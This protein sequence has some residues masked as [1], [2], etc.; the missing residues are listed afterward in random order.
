MILLKRHHQCQDSSTQYRPV[1]RRR[2]NDSPTMAISISSSSISGLCT[3][4]YISSKS[5]HTFQPS[6][7]VPLY[8]IPPQNFNFPMSF[9][10][11]RLSTTTPHTIATISSLP[12]ELLLEILSHLPLIDI[13]RLSQ[14]CRK[15]ELF[16]HF[17]PK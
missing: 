4:S 1:R 9:L 10:R 13:I 7:P 15:V 12:V 8:P 6:S 3:E 5:S 2:L 14:T 16:F 17:P 11:K